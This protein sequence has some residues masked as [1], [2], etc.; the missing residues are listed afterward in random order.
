M[1]VARALVDAVVVV[2]VMLEVVIAGRTVLLSTT[3]LVRLD[4]LELRVQEFVDGT[5]PLARL[6]IPRYVAPISVTLPHESSIVA[7]GPVLETSLRKPPK[8]E[9]LVT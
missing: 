8:Y 6:G 9:Y 1:S 2:G 5:Y 7:F 3:E 4:M